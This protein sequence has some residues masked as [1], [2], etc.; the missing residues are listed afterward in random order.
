MVLPQMAQR[1]SKNGSSWSRI[2]SSTRLEIL[3]HQI[4]YVLEQWGQ[5]CTWVVLGSHLAHVSPIHNT[6]TNHNSGPTLGS[7]GLFFVCLTSTKA[8]LFIF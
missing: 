3:N 7:W 5:C 2:L 4:E 6:L 8:S 1:R